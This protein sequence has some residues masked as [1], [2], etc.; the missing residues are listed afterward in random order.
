MGRTATAWLGFT[1][2]LGLAAAAPARAEEVLYAIDAAGNRVAVVS[3]DTSAVVASI[4]VGTNPAR[5]VFSADGTRAYVTNQGSNSVS[6]IDTAARAVIQTI[7]VG[8]GPIGIAITPDGSKLYTNNNGTTTGSVISTQ[9]NTVIATLDVNAGTGWGNVGVG[10][11]RD[12]SQVWFGGG[13]AQD[14][15]T[16]YSIPNHS[17]V[18]RFGG[19]TVVRGTGDWI[20]FTPDGAAWVVNGC[21]CCGNIERFATPSTSRFEYLFNGGG[22]GLAIP[23]DG[24][25]VY[26]TGAGHC[27]GTNALF[28]FNPATQQITRTRPLASYTSYPGALCV[29]AAGEKIY[30]VGTN[31]LICIDRATFTVERTI[32][33]TFSPTALGQSPVPPPP[34]APAC[35]DLLAAAES[36]LATAQAD[37]TA[38]RAELTTTKG[39]LAT[40]TTDLATAQA[41]V[42]AARAELT[43]TKGQLATATIDLATAQ[44]DV[45]AARAELTTTKGQ[46]ATATTDL[47]TAHA[48]LTKT[49]G[50]L[51]AAQADLATARADL[52]TARADLASARADLTSA[53]ADLATTA[54][55]LA[56]SRTDLAAANAALAARQAD[57]AA[58]LACLADVNAPLGKSGASGA[59]CP[60]GSL[61]V[62]YY[63]AAL[64]RRQDQLARDPRAGRAILVSPATAGGGK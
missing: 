41:D 30:V 1:V 44:A 32:N 6:V 54:A 52:S 3:L 48:D 9:T 8:A 47:A 29:D 57:L 42:T 49:Q 50:D 58:A 60:T 53:Q 5:L 39:Q 14:G 13:S 46:L 23:A 7:A 2:A 62:I 45:T 21:G 61:Q 31:N 18:A 51:S 40:A 64:L 27:G 22:S 55:A 4:P 43:T 37:A 19:F 28:E 63:D 56:Q 26:A 25:E 24:F 34:P 16:V 15:M 59:A 20:D 38:A 33:L 17:L 11:K 12:G 35:E 36:D 10:V